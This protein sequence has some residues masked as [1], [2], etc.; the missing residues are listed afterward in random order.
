MGLFITLM[1][2]KVIAF[3]YSGYLISLLIDWFP[4]GKSNDGLYLLFIPIVVLPGLFLFSCFEWMMVRKFEISN[5][6]KLGIFTPFL[7]GLIVMEFLDYDFFWLSLVITLVTSIALI[8][9]SIVFWLNPPK[10]KDN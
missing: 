1:I 4:W 8:L 3:V 9:G 5:I 6:M 2:S 10:L 7:L